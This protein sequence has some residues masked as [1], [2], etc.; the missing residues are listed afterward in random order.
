MAREY[1][2]IRPPRRSFEFTWVHGITWNQVAAEAP[3]DQVWPALESL[4]DG[5]E[6]LAAHNASFD[7][8]VLKAC[9]ERAGMP[10]PPVRFECT[11]RLA[12]RTWSLYPT[13]LPDVCRHLQIPLRHHDALSD[14]EACAAIVVAAS[15][16]AALPP[17]P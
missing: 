11:M 14:A 15:G 2:L 1:R 16:T 4:I 12:R 5:A 17:A 6:F 9:C 10:P 8:G 7:R 3:F 13:R